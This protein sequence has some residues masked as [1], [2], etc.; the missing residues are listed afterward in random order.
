M[1]CV[2]GADLLV[3]GVSSDTRSAGTRL[4]MDRH[5][6]GCREFS[7]ASRAFDCLADVFGRAEVLEE[8]HSI[9][10]LAI[11]LKGHTGEQNE[12]E[13]LKV[14]WSKSLLTIAEDFQRVVGPIQ[15][16]L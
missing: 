13:L 10:T 14:L 7:S 16:S 1:V 12:M 4:K 8:E 15:Q 5:G 11:A 9:R 3:D 2:M 6:G